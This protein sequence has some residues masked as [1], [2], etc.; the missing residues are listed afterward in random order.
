MGHNSCVGAG[1]YICLSSGKQ[2]SGA[3]PK[4]VEVINLI[5]GLNV[6]LIVLKAQTPEPVNVGNGVTL[7]NNIRNNIVFYLIIAD[8]LLPLMRE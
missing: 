8:Y 2:I 5:E 4:Q 7:L 3:Y 6:L 1:L